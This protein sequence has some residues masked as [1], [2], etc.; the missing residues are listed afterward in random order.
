[1]IY[2][3]I[4]NG[5]KLLSS[6]GAMDISRVVRKVGHRTSGRDHAYLVSFCIMISVVVIGCRKVPVG[7]VRSFPSTTT[8]VGNWVIDPECLGP[9]SSRYSI[10]ALRVTRLELLPNGTFHAFMLPVRDDSANPEFGFSDNTGP[11]RIMKNS[12]GAVHVRLELKDGLGYDLFLRKE[13]GRLVLVNEIEDPDSSV[14]V[15]LYRL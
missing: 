4:E 14:Q 15:V 6:M 9:L 11:W 5:M 12:S 2:H 7:P 8:I 3:W 1:M 13:G 10:S